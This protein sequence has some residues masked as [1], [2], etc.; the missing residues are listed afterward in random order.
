MDRLKSLGASPKVIGHGLTAD[1]L[2]ALAPDL[3]V[4]Y[5]YRHIINAAILALVECEIVNLHISLLPWNRGADPNLWSFLDDTPKGVSIH[6]VTPGLDQGPLVAQR[7]VQF[8]E[9]VETLASSYDRLQGEILDLFFEVLP[10]LLTG[11]AMAWPQSAGGSFHRLADLDDLRGSL[12]GP[13]GWSVPIYVLKDRF[14]SSKCSVR[15]VREE[16]ARQLWIWRNDPT[17]RA[18][19]LSTEEI[20]FSQHMVWFARTMADAS[21]EILIA[22]QAGHA[23]GMV[24]FER[25]GPVTSVHILLEPEAR[26]RGLARSVLSAAINASERRSTK[27]RATIRSNNAPSLALFRGLGFETVDDGDPVVLERD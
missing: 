8:D 12:L 26:G 6:R 9:A 10:T 16:D 25:E 21:R 7:E 14:A 24:R 1:I 15:L 11:N 4:S 20:P 22:E 17:V 23:M 27:L 19:S 18:A 13:E 5:S 2:R 3:I